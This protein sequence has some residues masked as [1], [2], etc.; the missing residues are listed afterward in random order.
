MVFL[1]SAESS[2]QYGFV[3]GDNQKK[4]DIPFE[5]HSNLVVVPLILNNRLPLKFILDTGVR[6]A[7]LTEKSYADIL[8]VSYNRKYTIRG[9]GGEKLVDA[10]VTNSVT[11]ALPGVD[12]KGHAM[13]VLDNDFIELRNFLGTEVH[14]ML[15]YELFSRFIVKINYQ[16]RV[17]TLI[18]PQYFKPNRTYQ[19]FDLSIE[20]TKPYITVPIK[21]KNGK[22]LHAKLMFDSG[23][24]HGLMLDTESG[25]SVYVPKKTLDANIGRGLGGKIEGRI[26]RAESMQFGKYEL[27]D[28]LVTYPYP[29]SYT[30]STTFRNGTLGGEIISRFTVI[31]DYVRGKLYLKKNGS[32]KRKFFFNMSGITIKAVGARLNQFE[33]DEVRK[34]SNAYKAGLRS[35]DRLLTINGIETK[36]LN[37]KMINGSFNTKPGRRVKLEVIRKGRKMQYSFR[38]ASPI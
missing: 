19:E 15:G 4:V 10:Y 27:K 12:G 9:A 13:L 28:P 1:I 35:G 11:L 36:S 8:D 7:I 32:F 23:A 21:Q 37:L 5:I 17:L 25:D 22:T 31:Y 33:I 26:G 2:A 18:E 24:S 3:L 14:G 16:R 20:D 34:T 38:L 30:D 6:N 29:G